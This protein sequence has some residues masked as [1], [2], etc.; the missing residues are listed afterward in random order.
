M[1]GEHC[2]VLT[3][4]SMR[5]FIGFDTQTVGSYQTIHS[6]TS[7][8]AADASLGHITHATVRTRAHHCVLIKQPL[9]SD[10]SF[11]PN[12][13][14][15][16]A[17]ADEMWEAWSKAPFRARFLNLFSLLLIILTFLSCCV[18]FG[19]ELFTGQSIDPKLPSQLTFH[20]Y[21]DRVESELGHAHFAD[22]YR[23][24]GNNSCTDGGR[25][26]VAFAAVAFCTLTAV[27]ALAVCRIASVPIAAVQLPV[28]GRS[29]RL[30]WSL[31]VLCVPLLLL[32]VSCYG[33]LCYQ[34]F[35]TNGEFNNVRA[36]GYAYSTL[37]V[38][39]AVMQMGVGWALRRDEQCWLGIAEDSAHW[40]N[41]ALGKSDSYRQE[42]LSGFEEGSSDAEEGDREGG[43]EEEVADQERQPK[44]SR[45]KSHKVRGKHGGKRM[46]IEMRP[47][48]PNYNY[49]YTD[50]Y[51]QAAV[52]TAAE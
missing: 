50:T 5:P 39:C 38:F 48:D 12:L 1:V 20:F 35:Q 52:E 25:L 37:G 18:S 34:P 32:S 7:H 3:G 45:H 31:S 8:E 29:V 40:T 16:S 23:Y 41:K 44:R 33:S 9:T 19:A 47:I 26:L 46:K 14:T 13:P 15:F 30:E 42:K 11:I 17:I 6:V 49:T 10:R 28:P 36:T 21:H 43:E 22:M 4:V 51:Q 27:L 24:R 2:A